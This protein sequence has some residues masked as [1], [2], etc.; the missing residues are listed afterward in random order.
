MALLAAGGGAAID[1]KYPDKYTPMYRNL[2]RGPVLRGFS[3]EAVHVA[4]SPSLSAR[5]NMRSET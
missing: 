1:G 4:G 5:R 2:C 3:S